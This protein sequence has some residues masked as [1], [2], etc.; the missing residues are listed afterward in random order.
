M[1]TPP[2]A[3][4]ETP[5]RVAVACG[6]AHGG[7]WLS[8]ALATTG[9][10][11]TVTEVVGPEGA[12][13]HATR[14][15]SDAIVLVDSPTLDAV[16]LSRGLR[17]VGYDGAIVVVGELPAQE[18]EPMTIE[19]GADA[20]RCAAATSAAL[21]ATEMTRCVAARRLAAPPR[22]LASREAHRLEGDRDE[23]Q[24]L[25]DEQR[26]LVGALEGLADRE[27]G[28]TPDGADVQP[29]VVGV[30][31]SD[32]Y[33]ELLRAAI[34]EG[35]EGLSERVAALAG[36]L[37]VAGTSAPA[38]LALHVGA[39]ERLLAGLGERGARHALARADVLAMD[40]VVHLA[41]RYRAGYVAASP[42]ATRREAPPRRL[43]PRRSITSA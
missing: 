13:V 19:A 16:H 27:P 42:P 5:L 33:D 23:T 25:L 8:R 28:R 11:A 14:V 26:A 9:L 15:P 34:L 40:L 6:A 39:V 1:P 37:A 32:R 38:A 3:A 22:R 30:E 12:I 21:L 10:S 7:A 35:G 29:A 20:Y 43:L 41:E 36:E 24:R 4:V 18:R 2:A 31:L 17:G